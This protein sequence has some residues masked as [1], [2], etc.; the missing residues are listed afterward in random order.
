VPV[1]VQGRASALAAAARTVTPISRLTENDPGT[2][3]DE[4]CAIQQESVRA[5]GRVSE[6]RSPC[7]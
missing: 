2:T 3:V 7:A 1:D 4:A 6:A 5:R